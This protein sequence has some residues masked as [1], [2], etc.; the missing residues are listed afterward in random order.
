M[1][2][3]GDESRYW[4]CAYPRAA[5]VALGLPPAGCR[6]ARELCERL[7][8]RRQVGLDRFLEQ[9]GL[10][11]RQTFGRDSEAPALVQRQFLG[12]LV[13]LALAPGELPILRDE[14]VVQGFGI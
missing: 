13:D 3:A 6:F 4:G 14:Q 8:H 1:A 11:R 12:E 10:F 5:G 2:G 7:G 9:L